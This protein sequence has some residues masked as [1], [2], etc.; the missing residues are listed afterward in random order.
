[1]NE[2]WKVV[3]NYIISL[4]SLLVIMVIAWMVKRYLMTGLSSNSLGVAGLIFTVSALLANE[5]NLNLAESPD[6][7][8]PEKLNKW[9]YIIFLV[10]GMF[11]F[12]LWLL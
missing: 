8:T 2:H 4:L 1:M 11:L 9:I 12:F 5:W 3:S 10:V 7:I 6:A